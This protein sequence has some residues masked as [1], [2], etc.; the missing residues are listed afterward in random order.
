MSS[1]FLLDANAS[2]ET[3]AFLRQEL[4]LDCCDLRSAGLHHLGDEEIVA[5]D[6]A[7]GRVV[8]TFDTDFGEF[9]HR[10]GGV[11]ACFI[12]LRWRDQRI[13]AVNGTLSVFF[14]TLPP[15]VDLARSLVTIDERR[16][17][18]SSEPS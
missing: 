8:I 3:T 2:S 4:G 10:T 11:H 9:F 14:R 6:L 16:V 13:E 17:R 15:D 7:E 12:Q 1:R 5:L 18:I